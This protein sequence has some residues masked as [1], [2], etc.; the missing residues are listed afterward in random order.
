MLVRQLVENF[1][2]ERS[3]QLSVQYRRLE[4]FEQA[5]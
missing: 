3:R 2:Y 1:G 5:W 4:V